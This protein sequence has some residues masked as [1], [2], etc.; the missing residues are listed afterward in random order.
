M[1]LKALT[2]RKCFINI[3][4]YSKESVC[5]LSKLGYIWDRKEGS[6]IT[7]LQRHSPGLPQGPELLGFT[8]AGF[9]H[10][11]L[12]STASLS[13]LCTEIMRCGEAAQSCPT[14]CNPMN[15]S[16]PGSSVHGIFQ[17][18]TLEWVAISF[19]RGS[20]WPR[21]QNQVSHIVGRHF[22]VL[23]TREANKKAPKKEEKQQGFLKYLIINLLVYKC[24]KGLAQ[25]AVNVIDMYVSIHTL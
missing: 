3:S 6:V 21:S 24:H 1:P 9:S 20:S 4:C 18:R 13:W 11:F 19:S 8:L 25:G 16:L 12:G 22:T 7:S 23:A 5:N 2:P 15:C 14:L 17:A 10:S